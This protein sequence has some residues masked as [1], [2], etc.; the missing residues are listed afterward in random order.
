VA[1]GESQLSSAIGTLLHWVLETAQQP[2]EAALLAALEGRWGELDF[3]AEWIGTRERRL[4]DKMACAI[5]AYLDDRQ[6]VGAE[7]LGGEQAFAFRCGRAE[8]RGKIDRLE[9]ETGGVVVVDLKTSKPSRQVKQKDAGSHPQL[10]AYQLAVLEGAVA[11]AEGPSGGARLLYVQT[12]TQKRYSLVEQAPLADDA[13]A[14][15]RARLAEAAEGMSAAT[16]DGPLDAEER[17]GAPSLRFALP[18]ISEVCGD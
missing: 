12:T 13:A 17:F 3:E 14:V 6:K 5:A 18:R 9:R 15:F 11:G 8:V 10:G 4:A 16:F 1:G 7:L 2:D